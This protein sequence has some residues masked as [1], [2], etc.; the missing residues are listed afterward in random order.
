MK[1]WIV[2]YCT[3]GRTWLPIV[4]NFK[5]LLECSEMFGTLYSR[6]ESAVNHASG[7]TIPIK[8]I[9]IILVAEDG[10]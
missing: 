10:D 2:L 9:V 6:V 1:L 3:L 5:F 8:D 7:E 4:E